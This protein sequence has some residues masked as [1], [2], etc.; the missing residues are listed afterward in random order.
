MSGSLASSKAFTIYRLNIINISYHLISLL[1]YISEIS[2]FLYRFIGVKMQRDVW[3]TREDIGN[4][5]F[6][7][8]QVFFYLYSFTGTF[9]HI[10]DHFFCNSYPFQTNSEFDLYTYPVRKCPET[11]RQ[12][13]FCVFLHFFPICYFL[14]KQSFY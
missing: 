3:Q 13:F 14:I 1:H 6:L 11:T 2:Y 4:H 9:P 7:V 5:K 10:F 12:H 8:V